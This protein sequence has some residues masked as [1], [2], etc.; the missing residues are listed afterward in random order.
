MASRL[1]EQVLD[2]GQEGGSTRAA[3]EARNDI[4]EE[5]ATKHTVEFSIWRRADCLRKCAKIKKSQIYK[6]YQNYKVWIMQFIYITK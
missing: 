4:E 1:H 2:E 5:A 6:K 3:D